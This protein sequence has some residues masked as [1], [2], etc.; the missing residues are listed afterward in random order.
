MPMETGTGEPAPFS[1]RKR[2]RPSS[3]MPC[4][5]PV[6][7]W[8]ASA[9]LAPKGASNIWRHASL[10]FAPEA[11]AGAGGHPATTV[12]AKVDAAF[13]IGGH[14]STETKLGCSVLGNLGTFQNHVARGF[15]LNL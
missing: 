8:P 6:I 5:W 15:E 14:Y 3:S 4:R 12:L 9:F 2:M 1:A 10:W 13:D 11:A 7:T